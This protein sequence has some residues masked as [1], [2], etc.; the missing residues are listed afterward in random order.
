MRVSTSFVILAPAVCVSTCAGPD[1]MCVYPLPLSPSSD[2]Q[3]G[4]G[5]MLFSCTRHCVFVHPV[6]GILTCLCPCNTQGHLAAM[7]KGRWVG[8]TRRH[9][10]L[11]PSFL[12]VTDVWT[13]LSLCLSPVVFCVSHPMCQLLFA[14]NVLPRTCVVLL[15]GWKNP[16][17]DVRGTCTLRALLNHD[18]VYASHWFAMLSKL[19]ATSRQLDAT[20]VGVRACIWRGQRR[21]W[22]NCLL[23]CCCG[24]CALW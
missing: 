1:W 4:N 19:P 17:R 11:V 8:S 14:H 5:P 3:A 12:S 2:A 9:G 6:A 23:H 24:P 13:A 20:V 7:Y 21:L 15:L 22:E 18:C 16:W 10:R